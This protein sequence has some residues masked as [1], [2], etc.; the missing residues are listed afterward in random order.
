MLKATY[1]Q[2]LESLPYYQGI[3]NTHIIGNSRL[4]YNLAKTWKAIKT[5]L[6]I[7]QAQEK[8]LFESYGA[9]EENGNLSIDPAALPKKKQA[10]FQKELAD[11]K[12]LSV[13]IWGHPLT[14][15]E[16]DK[17]GLNFS[18]AQFEALGWMIAEETETIS[19]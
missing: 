9:K 14:L 3:L 15:E 1:S 11:L 2:L 13:E 16:L 19:S 6:T 18:P 4:S 8:Q 10:T 12:S 17:A 7:L 5:E